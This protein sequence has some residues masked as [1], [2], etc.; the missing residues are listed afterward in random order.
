MLNK[1]NKEQ[2]IDGVREKDVFNMNTWSC[3]IAGVAVELAGYEIPNYYSPE[4]VD[5][6]GNWDTIRDVARKLVSANHRLFSVSTWGYLEE[7]YDIAIQC[8]N[9]DVKDVVIRA[10]ELFWE[11][12]NA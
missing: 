11:D 1:I 3:C 6:N 4:C 2:L 12:E 5:D 10:I 9:E 7:S 8:G